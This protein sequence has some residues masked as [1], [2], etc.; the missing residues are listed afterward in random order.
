MKSSYRPLL[1][2]IIL[3]VAGC[4]STEIGTQFHV[5]GTL[6]G[7]SD[8]QSMT[9][10]LNDN[11]QITLTQ[12]GLFEFSLNLSDNADYSVAV[13]T[14]PQGQ[15]CT[16]NNAKGKISK[17]HIDNI[18]VV[19]LNEGE[20]SI[21]VDIM[22]LDGQLGIALSAHPSGEET[23]PG[24]TITDNL[25]LDIDG[26]YSFSRSVPTSYDYRV[27]IS[28][29]PEKLVCSVSAPSGVIAGENIL[30][31][32]QCAPKDDLDGDGLSNDEELN[33][34]HTSPKIADTDGDGYSDYEEVITRGFNTA[35]NFKFNPR[36]A[37][38][39]KL[40]LAI[41][42][43]PI[44][45]LSVTKSGSSETHNLKNT[46]TGTVESSERSYTGGFAVELTGSTKEGFS[47]TVSTDHHWTKS[48]TKETYDTVEQ[49]TGSVTLE[50][51]EKTGGSL[52]STVKVSNEGNRA[53]TLT[54]LLLN[55]SMTNASGQR[56]P[57]GSLS[58]EGVSSFPN[59]SL[60]PLA[61][62]GD[63]IFSNSALFPNVAEELLLK[64]KSIS[65]EISSYD[66][67]DKEGVSM[68]YIQ[69]QAQA[70][71]AQI[72]IDYANHKL[73]LDLIV[74]TNFN[75]D[76]PGATLATL[77]SD[78][79]KLDVILSNY[80]SVKSLNGVSDG[81]KAN[82][83]W[84][85]IHDAY[86]G[87]SSSA[88]LYDATQSA[89]KLEDIMVRAGDKIALV[90]LEDDDGD[91]L[92]IR[93]EL[94]LGTDPTLSDTDGD[95]L[96]DYDEIYKPWVVTAI[97]ALYPQRYPAQIYSD[98]TIADID[99]DGDNDSLEK[100]KGNDPYNNDTD[101]DG[102]NDHIDTN[103]G[104]GNS[105]AFFLNEISQKGASEFSVSGFVVPDPG[106]GICTISMDWGDSSPI[107]Q[108][109]VVCT[110]Q[111]DQGQSFDFSHTY[112]NA[113][114]S[115][116][117]TLT[118]TDSNSATLGRTFV[119]TTTQQFSFDEYDFNKGWRE[120][121]YFREVQDI[122]RDGRADIVGIGASGVWVSKGTENGFSAPEKWST[123]WVLP[124]GN[125]NDT[126]PKHLIDIDA[127][128][129]LDLVGFYPAN[130]YVSIN[131]GTQF[132][133]ATNWYDGLGKNSG[134]DINK[135][136]RMFGDVDGNGYIDIVAFGSDSVIVVLSNGAKD[137]N[138]DMLKISDTSQTKTR[139]F[140]AKQFAYNGGWKVYRHPR[141]VTDLNRDGKA[142]ILAIGETEAWALLGLGD[143][144]FGEPV[145]IMSGE[146]FQIMAG[147]GSW[148]DDRNYPRML[149]D[150]DSDGDQDIVGFGVNAVYTIKNTSTVN[151]PISFA[152][153][154]SVVNDFSYN[155]GWR[156]TFKL[157][158][159]NNHHKHVRTFADVN[160]DGRL[161][162][163]G[164]GNK[165]VYAS[166]N[167]G[168]GQFAKATT[169]NSGDFDLSGSTGCNYEWYH[170]DTSNYQRYFFTRRAAD[171]NGDGAADLV[172]FGRCATKV[173]FTSTMN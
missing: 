47:T 160:G 125:T 59:D 98:P 52:S 127:D 70:Q 45:T 151:G 78:I 28:T 113:T 6:V 117:A 9:L 31:P 90:Y 2:W 134:W 65:L 116:T 92:G 15:S 124:S 49:T 109:V 85:I 130:V 136:L 22:G 148:T 123:E 128:G 14:P 66:I 89:Y 74:A 54:Y 56:V 55:A 129:D 122:D 26:I 16:V 172:G 57:I 51:W 104:G 34:Y 46:T 60:E 72:I 140:D 39:P 133:K 96:S 115:Y 107:S 37:D 168:D 69:E 102:T 17:A 149:A 80:G 79:L 71:G 135:H 93:Q 32:I 110:D 154:T 141:W 19:C 121:T 166:L 106:A 81:D 143:G 77:L 18:Q 33:V 108:K 62:T 5:S 95:G 147:N 111:L 58:L 101:G 42:S 20:Y 145:S 163:V 8:D 10:S 120:A 119:T 146:D 63:L 4:S 75:P 44:V 53:F 43:E 169:W 48:N 83:K 84:V 142:D 41:T 61:S 1:L 144:N 114:T 73:P 64:S 126:I 171:V 30:V 157:D 24:A 67:A 138:G 27:D 132:R 156:D 76:V 36:I 152:N 173:V 164:F 50:G 87:V 105:Y 150:I 153:Q 21:S 161:D 112:N 88:K 94:A 11:N 40:K 165:G 131:D 13:L 25:T 38:L 118:S 82:A 162:I 139:M 158:G 97:N 3:S 35:Q 159:W 91:G 29:A 155:P 68:A 23:D 99:G 86:D 12:N 100:S 167:T 7:M 170:N 103:A 137:D